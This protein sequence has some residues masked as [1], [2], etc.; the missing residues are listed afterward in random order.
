MK[1]L[2]AMATKQANERVQFGKPIREFGL[3][4]QKVGQ[5]VIDCYATESV[6]SMV[7]G[8]VDDQ[9][10]EYAIEAAISKVLASEN[11]WRT[12]DEALQI[13]AGNGYMCEFPY[14]R[15]LRDCRINRIFEGTNDILR[16]F[17]ALSAMKDVGDDLKELARSLK[18]V[19]DDP[20]KGFGVIR[21]YALRRAALAAGVNRERGK[22]TR[23]HPA[24]KAQ[25]GVFEDRTRDLASAVDR[26]LR[27]HG[28]DIIDKQLA[29]R[30]LADIMIDLFAL[31]CVLSRVSSR[32]EA[33]G[34]AASAEEL[35][36]ARALTGQASRRIGQNLSEMEQNE[37]ELVKQLADTAFDREG[38]G[39]D[40]L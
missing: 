9:V 6:V 10:E 7:A 16:L 35:S 24:L 11:L 29:T 26:T 33:E 27:R 40:T 19:F 2:I 3:I 15:L 13:A 39:W 22:L 30:R 18:G 32:L 23:V 8:L 37:D 14:E 12:A 20:I 28:K 4:K 25:A 21:G 1:R 38:Y 36:I 31:A 34:E 5:M 17:I